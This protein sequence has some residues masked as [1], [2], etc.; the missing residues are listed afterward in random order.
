MRRRGKYGTS[1]ANKDF[2]LA[3]RHPPPMIVPHDIALMTMQHGHTIEPRTESAHRLRRQ[4]NLR[5]QH[6]RL[7]PVSHDLLDRA[8]VNLRFTASGDAMNQDRAVL[9]RMQ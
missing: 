8:N 5:H 4:A 3:A 9:E 1:R 7:P 2:S 6:N